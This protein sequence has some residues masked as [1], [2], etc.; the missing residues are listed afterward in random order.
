MKGHFSFAKTD[1]PFSRMG[2]DQLHE[3]NNK[4]IKGV[5][6]ATNLLN[7]NDESALNRW[8]LS[9]PDLS[10]MIGEFDEMF[11]GHSDNVKNITSLRLPFNKIFPEM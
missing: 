3:Q 8:A 7:R 11:Q 5:S 10:Q 2:L 1:K 6:G 9:A 4:V